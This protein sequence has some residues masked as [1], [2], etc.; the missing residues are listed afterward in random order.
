MTDATVI[1]EVTEA[2]KQ[3]LIVKGGWWTLGIGSGP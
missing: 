2:R 3:V 1:A